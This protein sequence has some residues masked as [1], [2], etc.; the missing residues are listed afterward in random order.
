LISIKKYL[1]TDTPAV[2][3][4]EPEPNE[5]LA[6]T[7]ESYRSA[8][9]A[10]G[11]SAVQACPAPGR[12]LE[13]GLAS[14]EGYLSVN[15]A[16]KAVKQTQA[17]VED[18]LQKWGSQTAEH[19]KTKADEVKELLIMLAHTAESIGERDKRYSAQ[20]GGFTAE[21]K[22]ISNLDDLTQIRSS[23]VK[24]AT[25]LKNCVDQMS[26]DGQQSLAQLRSKVSGYETKLQAVELAASKD[27]LTGVAN[28]RS[29]E[30]RMERNIEANQTFCVAILDLNQF[31]QVNDKYGHAAGDDL[32]KK[33][34]HELQNN[35]RSEDLVGRWGGDEFIVLLGRDLVAA[36]PQI[37]RIRQWVFGDYSL[38]PG[39]GKPPQKIHIDASVGVAQWSRGKTVKQLVEE[40]DAAMY[41]DKRNSRK[42]R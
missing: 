29:M 18:Q 6:V 7:I 26:Q 2:A 27:T 36:Q 41:R 11:R 14:L 24:K 5:L 37:E 19:L 17:Q 1:D 31:K 13:Q 23:L 12:E 28:R 33:F 38:E 3:V 39:T 20:I 34:S 16:P 40:A 9:Q 30:K 22:A 4:E 21:L 8:L 35:V 32:L 10:I 25:E 42:G 15:A